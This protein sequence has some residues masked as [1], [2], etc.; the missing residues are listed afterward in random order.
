MRPKVCCRPMLLSQEVFRSLPIVLKRIFIKNLT[1]S[2][3]IN[4]SL[5]S[6][7]TLISSRKTEKD[8]LIVA[9]IIVAET[10]A[11]I[12]R[13]FRDQGSKFRHETRVFARLLPSYATI[14]EV[15]RSLTIVFE[16]SLYVSLDIFLF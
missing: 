13:K 4:A 7:R 14:Q 16:L 2:I 10:S 11:T 3:H 8:F 5:H 1:C 6:K 12:I 9:S 15:F